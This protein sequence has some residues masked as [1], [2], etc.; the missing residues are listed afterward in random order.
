YGGFYRN[1]LRNFSWFFTQNQH[2]ENLLKTIQISNVSVAGDTRFDRVLQ[3][4][5]NVKSIPVVEEFKAGKAI[6]VIGSCWPEDLSLLMPFIKNHYR[7]LK[8]II[9]PH[10]IHENEVRNLCNDFAGEAV[11][12]SEAPNRAVSEYSVLIID[13]I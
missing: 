4:A 8:F 10:E 2:S 5:Q 9:A 6:F 3:T 1:I 7:E 12:F 13:N 11:R